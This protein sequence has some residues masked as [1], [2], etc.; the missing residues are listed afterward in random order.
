MQFQPSF[1][2]VKNQHE[3]VHCED[4]VSLHYSH[5]TKF[6]CPNSSIFNSSPNNTNY[7]CDNLLIYHKSLS[8]TLQVSLEFGVLKFQKP[9]FQITLFS[10][11]W[12]F[13]LFFYHKFVRI[14]KPICCFRLVLCFFN[15]VVPGKH[16]YAS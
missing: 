16:G 6:T 12:K 8:P 4:Q 14:R 3:R 1:F 10:T 15:W 11:F 13:D 9:H 5:P 2:R 7:F